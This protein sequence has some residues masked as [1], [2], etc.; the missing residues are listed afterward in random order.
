MNIQEANTKEEISLCYP[1]LLSLRSHL[2]LETTIVKVLAQQNE[3]YHLMYTSSDNIV[4]AILG[5]RI[6]NSLAW[7]KT[8]YIDDLATLPRFQKQGFASHLL[9]WSI[10]RAQQLGCEQL[11]LDTGFDRKDAQR[12]YLK[13]NFNF[14]SH[15]MAIIL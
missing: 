4:T 5:Y 12:L 14:A 1:V 3:G 8:F 15:H 11:H 2:T 9:E 6:F 7:G 10:S 13:H